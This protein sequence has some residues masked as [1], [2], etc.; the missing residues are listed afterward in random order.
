MGRLVKYFLIIIAIYLAIRTV[1]A[2]FFYDQL[3]VP[4]LVSEFDQAQI[5]EYR[6]RVL[7]PGFFLTLIYFI[8]RYF[9]GKN[10][11][12]AM[13]P[14]YVSTISL[15]IT[16]IIGFITFL[17]LTKDTIIMFIITLVIFLVAR[18]AHHNRKNEIF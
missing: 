8:Y 7:I 13:W 4:F 3:P 6:V 10:P 11:T 18:Q 14:I 2:L 15:L 12:S 16:H 1:V 5:N 9:S 17:P